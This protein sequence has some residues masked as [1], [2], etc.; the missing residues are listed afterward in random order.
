MALTYRMSEELDTLYYQFGSSEGVTG[1]V[2][3]LGIQGSIYKPHHPL[4]HILFRPRTGL[5]FHKKAPAV[6][7]LVYDRCIKT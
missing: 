5:K 2:L 7:E 6:K 3:A 4:N 1:E